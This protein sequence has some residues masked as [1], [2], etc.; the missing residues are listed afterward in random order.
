MSTTGTAT[1]S[2]ST[3][4]YQYGAYVGN[5]F[6]DL[7]NIL[8]FSGNDFETSSSSTSD[9]NDALAVAE[10]IKSTDPSALQSIELNYAAR[11]VRRLL[12]R[13]LL[14]ARTPHGPR[15]ST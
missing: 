1:T 13:R 3:T 2:P 5:Q 8:W 15:C 9:N 6:K 10:G 14:L 12:L 7:H 4:D 11:R